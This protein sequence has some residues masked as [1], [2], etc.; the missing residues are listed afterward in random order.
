MAIDNEGDAVLTAGTFPG[1][2]PIDRSAAGLQYNSFKGNTVST[3]AALGKGLQKV[4]PAPVSF[5]PNASMSGG[6]FGSGHAKSVASF[7]SPEE[8]E[9]E[10]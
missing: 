3:G 10:E 7:S 1:Q 2:E 4:F 6:Q 9:T 8:A 5:N